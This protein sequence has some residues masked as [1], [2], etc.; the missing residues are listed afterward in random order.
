MNRSNMTNMA[1]TPN[2]N[3][4]SQSESQKEKVRAT[5]GEIAKSRDTQSP[6]SCCAP[7]CCAPDVN[8]DDVNTDYS[9]EEIAS[10]PEGAYLGEGSGNPVLAAKLKPGETVVD[11]GSGAGMD[12]Y[13]AANLVGKSGCVVGLDM[14]PEMLERA[15][16][17]SARGDYPQVTFRQADIEHLPLESGTADAVLSNCVINLAPDKAAVY[18]EIHRVLKPGGRFAIADI[19][20][21]G[22]PDSIPDA[23]QN[24]DA[25]GCIATAAEEAAYL[26]IIRAVGFDDV[27]IVSERPAQSQPKDSAVRSQAVTLVGKKPAGN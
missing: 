27:K 23:V 26:D 11:L 3:T 8:T 4:L 21:R 12:S 13:L 20:L 5:Y 10:V 1:N 14:T 15:R 25:C 19:V 6:A 22:D 7:T 24:L 2:T 17:N 18:R 16:K 9:S